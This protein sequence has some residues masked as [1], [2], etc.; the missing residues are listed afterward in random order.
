MVV[1]RISNSMTCE[2][3]RVTGH[4]QGHQSSVD[5]S[6][7][8]RSALTIRYRVCSTRILCGDQVLLLYMGS[9]FL[10]RR[11]QHSLRSV[12]QPTAD[13]HLRN[14][15]FQLLL[16]MMIAPDVVEAEEHIVDAIVD[17]LEPDIV[18]HQGEATKI[19]LQKTRIAPC[20]L[21]LRTR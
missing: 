13:I 4:D 6:R 16:S 17:F 1:R 18:L 14:H 5:L 21:T 11:R 9:A 15:A 3:R 12:R 7:V 10:S 8:E 2:A 19:W 20:R